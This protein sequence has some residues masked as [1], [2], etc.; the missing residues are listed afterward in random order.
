MVAVWNCE[1]EGLHYVEFEADYQS[2]RAFRHNM[3]DLAWNPQ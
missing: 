2:Y 3:E 1:R